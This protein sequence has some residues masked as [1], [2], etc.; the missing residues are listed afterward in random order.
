MVEDPEA[1]TDGAPLGIV[2]PVHHA[3]NPGLNDCACAHG[4][5]LD[6]DVQ[7]SSQ[8]AVISDG[9]GGSAERQNFGVRGWVAERN[10]A[11]ARAGQDAFSKRN[12]RAYRHFALFG[13]GTRLR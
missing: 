3:K 6:G 13:R 7:S 8:D 5:R 4:A 9:L 1:G 10:R 2:A 11:I 12:N